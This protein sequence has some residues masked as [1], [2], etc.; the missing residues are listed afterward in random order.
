MSNEITVYY[1]GSG[2]NEATCYVFEG[3]Y[4]IEGSTN[5]SR[6]DEVLED[7]INVEIIDNYDFMTASRPV[8]S[9]E[10]LIEEIEGNY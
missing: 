2:T 10:D 9:I 5:I 4:C 3:W 6:T 8:E 7:G 1:G